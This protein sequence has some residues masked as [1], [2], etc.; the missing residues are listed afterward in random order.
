MFHQ[1]WAALLYL[2]AVLLNSIYQ[3]PEYSPLTTQGVDGKEVWTEKGGADGG[4][5]EGLGWVALDD[6]KPRWKRKGERV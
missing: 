2:C 3:C 4:G 6:Q 1:I 5:S